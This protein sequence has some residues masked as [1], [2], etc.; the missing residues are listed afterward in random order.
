MAVGILTGPVSEAL[1]E[2]EYEYHFVEYEYEYEYDQ[3][4]PFLDGIIPEE[5][6]FTL[7][8]ELLV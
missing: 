6:Y 8:F 4:H 1:F 5:T 7:L 3:E 2:Y